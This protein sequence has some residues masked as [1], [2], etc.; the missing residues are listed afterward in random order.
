MS[1]VKI[2][3][4]LIRE[5]P[6]VIT[7]IKKWFTKVSEVPNYSEDIR[8]FEVE[9]QGAFDDDVQLFITFGRDN[10]GNVVVYN[11]DKF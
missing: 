8:K 10:E 2:T 1:Y 9:G 3:N 6:E 4:Q 7:A 5:C 11:V